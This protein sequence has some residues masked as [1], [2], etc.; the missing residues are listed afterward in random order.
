MPARPKKNSGTCHMN[1]DY[2]S[3]G[4]GLLVVANTRSSTVI[5]LHSS[6]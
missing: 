1:C 5:A 2:S 4:N 3:S 6:R